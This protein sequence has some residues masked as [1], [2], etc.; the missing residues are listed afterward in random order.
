MKTWRPRSQYLSAMSSHEEL[1]SP[2]KHK[3]H[4]PAPLRWIDEKFWRD[5]FTNV[6][7][8]VVTAILAYIYALLAGYIARPDTLQLL[9]SGAALIAPLF[10]G[11]Y[12]VRF[13]LAGVQRLFGEAVMLRVANA[14][15]VFALLFSVAVTI[16][17]FRGVFR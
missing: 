9:L 3:R 11:R 5:L 6:V 7:A 12:G 13:G 17:N 8:F 14:F 2:A 16:Y 4:R 15:L 10:I 1:R